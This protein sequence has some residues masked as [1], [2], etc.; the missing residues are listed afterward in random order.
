VT[1]Q[2]GLV[3]GNRPLLP[4]RQ[5]FYKLSDLAK[6]ADDLGFSAIGTS[7]SAFVA[8]DSYVR[9]AA[10]ALGTERA[11]VGIRPTN[12]VTREPQVMAAFIAT[13]DQ[14]SG[15][16]AFLDV[17]SGDSAVLNAGLKPGS[18]ARI[19]AYIRC[20]RELLSQSESSF[21]GRRQEV[22]WS[23]GPRSRVPVWITAGG[24]KM[25][26]LAGRIGDG[27]VIGM[28]LTPEV[29][30]DAK[31]RV[32]EGALAEGRDPEAIELW[33]A[34]RCGFDADREK[35]VAQAQA[36][37]AGILHHT[38][39][40]GLTDKHVPEEL[41]GRVRE[42]V[43]EYGIAGH[44]LV[45]GENVKKMESL[46]LTQFAMERWSIAGDAADWIERIHGLDAVGASNLWISLSRGD[47]DEQ[48]ACLRT[49]GEQVIPEIL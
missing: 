31:K 34:T 24:P 2:L 46:G 11:A 13:L 29:V 28:G 14:L 32:R 25:L 19:E 22:R 37:A 49:F 10:I 15:G 4:G 5:D 39:H 18:R 38:M 41:Q 7:D 3:V 9:A 23:S 45:G 12:P 42:F 35:A 33:F 43:G 1:V 36:L 8:G 6:M 21:E 44:V 40:N 47:L 26:H 16:R 20:V 30:A 17:A 27:V 48:Q